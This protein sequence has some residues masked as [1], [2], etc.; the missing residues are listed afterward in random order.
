MSQSLSGWFEPSVLY[1]AKTYGPKPPSAVH[2]VQA[3][4]VDFTIKLAGFYVQ[5][6]Q[7]DTVII[8]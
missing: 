4:M 6:P 2:T 5:S 8:R 1:A 7:S 3:D